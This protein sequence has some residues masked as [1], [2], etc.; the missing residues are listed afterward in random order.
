MLGDRV[1]V[2]T[3]DGPVLMKV[4]PGARAG[5]RL[6]LRGKGLPYQ[7][8]RGDEYVVVKIDIPERLSAEEE[9]LYRELASLRKGV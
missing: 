4:P 3:L 6:R 9:K 1:S 5:K 7:K 8:G 2:P